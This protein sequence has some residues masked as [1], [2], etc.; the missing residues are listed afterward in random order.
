LAIEL[1]VYDSYLFMLFL[2]VFN[3]VI[4]VIKLP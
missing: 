2:V 3:D 1:L 4:Y